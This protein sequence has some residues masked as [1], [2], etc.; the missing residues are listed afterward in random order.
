MYFP[1]PHVLAGGLGFLLQS[2]EIKRPGRRL[3]PSLSPSTPFLPR[4]GGRVS[5]T[6][7]GEERSSLSP[8]L[9]AS[10]EGGFYHLFFTIL[11]AYPTRFC[12]A[13]GSHAV[14]GVNSLWK[15]IFRNFNVVTISH[16]AVICHKTLSLMLTVFF[17]WFHTDRSGVTFQLSQP[18]QLTLLVFSQLCRLVQIFVKGK[19]PFIWNKLHLCLFICLLV[20][21][22]TFCT[23]VGWFKPAL[24]IKLSMVLFSSSIWRV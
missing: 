1:I 22:E 20:S 16:P 11:K 9:S 6:D 8:L 21:Q 23:F 12:P 4:R 10:A 5:L 17:N 13:E 7:L 15:G 3:P 19:H 18:P 2:P 24:G 14:L